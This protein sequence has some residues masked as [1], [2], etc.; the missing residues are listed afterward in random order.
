MSGERIRFQAD[1]NFRASIIKGLRRIQP[2]IDFQTAAD[3]G[4]AGLPDPQVLALAAEQG[5]ILVSHDVTTMPVH[6]KDFLDSGEHSPGVILIPQTIGFREVIDAL[7]LVWRA[8]EPAEWT[9]LIV[10]LPW[11]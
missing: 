1:A 9:D 8:S 6:F 2:D 4:L 11:H 5:R 10:H 7:L 3:A